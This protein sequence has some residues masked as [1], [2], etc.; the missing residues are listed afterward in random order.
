MNLKTTQ[1]ATIE[2]N[3]L[4]ISIFLKY[5]LIARHLGGTSQTL[6]SLKVATNSYFR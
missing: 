4:S 5:I 6:V 3:L 1:S 2:N